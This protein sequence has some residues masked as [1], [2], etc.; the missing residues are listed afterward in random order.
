M[1]PI[2]TTILAALVAGAMAGATDVGKEAVL[3]VGRS[4]SGVNQG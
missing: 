4:L 1:D 2:T 3:A